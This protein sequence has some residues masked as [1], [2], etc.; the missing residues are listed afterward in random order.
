[1]KQIS[2]ENLKNKPSNTEIFN[3]ADINVGKMLT[4]EL[5]KRIFQIYYDNTLLRAGMV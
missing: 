3:L 1:M 4:E 2:F 5:E